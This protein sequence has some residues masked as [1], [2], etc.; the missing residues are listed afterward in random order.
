[1]TY[2]ITPVDGHY[3]LAYAPGTGFPS[4]F[5]TMLFSA[6]F[7]FKAD[8][9]GFQ[10]GALG[11]NPA[12]G[13]AGAFRGASVVATFPTDSSPR[14]ITVNI[15]DDNSYNSP[16]P[17]NPYMGIVSFDMDALVAGT[18]YNILVSIDSE[19]NVV[20]CYVNDAPLSVLPTPFWG[21]TNPIHEPVSGSSG[22]GDG[23]IFVAALNN[24]GTNPCVADCWWGVTGGFVDLGVEANRRLFINADLTPVFLGTNGQVPFGSAPQAYATVPPSGIALQFLTNRGSTGGTFVNTGLGILCTPPSPPPSTALRMGHVIA[25]S[26]VTE[27]PCTALQFSPSPTVTP[28]F[29]LRWSNT[30]GETWG[31]P[32]PQILSADPRAQPIW[33]RT[34]YA[35]D[36]V[37][38]LFW[39]FA[40][41]T[42][43][44]GAFVDVEPFGS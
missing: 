3:E 21:S 12:P 15:G 31:N 6:W 1:M 29:G 14:T 35:R 34:G 9:S 27:S 19:T 11:F 8:Q 25:T 33:L 28:N 2:A 40:F 16:V 41:N 43:V 5:A 18:Y 38:E 13:L 42:A 39:S 22:S 37:F 32:V 10:M 17:G 7:E 26:L 36:R 20:Q 24:V 23:S 30:R 44:N 4:T